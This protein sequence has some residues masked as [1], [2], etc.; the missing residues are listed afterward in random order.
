MKTRQRKLPFSIPLLEPVTV[1]VDCLKRSQ[2]FSKA[3]PLFSKESKESKTIHSHLK[4][5]QNYKELSQT[6]SM[7]IVLYQKVL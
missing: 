1:G 6:P 5:T 3:C 7:Y 2:S 4:A